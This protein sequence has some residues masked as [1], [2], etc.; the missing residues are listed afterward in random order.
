[1]S[2]NDFSD[3]PDFYIT[4]FRKEKNSNEIEIDYKL[5]E[6]FKTWY[7]SKN[8]LK[9]WSR[10]HFEKKLVELVGE[11]IRRQID[12]KVEEQLQAAEIR[13]LRKAAARRK[14]DDSE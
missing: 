12:A 4:G 10:K 13:E 7:K 1:M 9:R 6:E 8:N 2:E 11:D 5:T 14:K 3:S